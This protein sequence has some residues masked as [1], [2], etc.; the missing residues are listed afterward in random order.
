M[1]S[2]NTQKKN[3]DKSAVRARCV[4]VYI[5]LCIITLLM[6]GSCFRYFVPQYVLFGLMLVRPVRTET[7]RRWRFFCPM[8]DIAL[9]LHQQGGAMKEQEFPPG[10]FEAHGNPLGS[11]QTS[12]ENPREYL[13]V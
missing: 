5:H 12:H 4:R 11:Q 9:G 10:N 1:I 3:G 7:K 2:S 6:V 8:I 13:V